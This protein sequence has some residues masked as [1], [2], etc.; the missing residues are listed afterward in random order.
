MDSGSGSLFDP[1][2]LGCAGVKV[3]RLGIAGGFGVPAQAIEMAFERECNYFYH[4]AFRRGGMTQAI[5]NI[6]AKGKRG[7]LV[8]VC[9]VYMRWPWLFRRSFYSFLK[10]NNLDYVDVLLLGWYN[11][12]PQK[13]ILDICAELKEKKLVRHLAVSGHERKAFPEMAKT[14]LYGA[15][16]IRYNAVHRG[17]ETEIFPNLPDGT[18]DNRPGI[19]AYTVTSWQQLIKPGKMPTGEKTPAAADC[20]RF[21]LTNP[22]VDVCI[23]GPSSAAQMKENLAL[24]DKGPMSEEEMAWMRRVGDHIHG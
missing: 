3:G 24:L 1:R 11:N 10:K 7:E 13:R 5:K 20:Y 6:C 14:G 23:T 8:I 17:A 19:V 18:S 9:Q 16:H 15:F 21:V 2:V 4:G 22:N 12:E